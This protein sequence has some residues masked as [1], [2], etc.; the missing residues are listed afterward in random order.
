MIVVLFKLSCVLHGVIHSPSGPV[1]LFNQCDA[2]GLMLFCPYKA[3]AHLLS[4]SAEFAFGM[5]IC[6]S[7]SHLVYLMLLFQGYEA[8][9][10]FW[11]KALYIIN[12]WAT[13]RDYK[14]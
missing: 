2:V 13:P 5:I 1:S 3:L 4:S 12:P 8:T 7:R 9:F 14:M 10:S 6:Q 11:L